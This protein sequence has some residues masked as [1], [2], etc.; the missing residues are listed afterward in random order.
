V[1]SAGGGF[2]VDTDFPTGLDI[3]GKIAFIRSQFSRAFTPAAG[4]LRWGRALRLGEL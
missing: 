4:S 3:A 1:A 2:S